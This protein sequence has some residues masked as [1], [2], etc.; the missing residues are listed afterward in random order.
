VIEDAEPF[1]DAP[2]LGGA[3][4]SAPRAPAHGLTVSGRRRIVSA[5]T[6]GEPRARD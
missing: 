6:L 4:R 1:V 5:A 2:G 3:H